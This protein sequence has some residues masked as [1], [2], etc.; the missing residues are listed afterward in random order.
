MRFFNFSSQ[1]RQ[2]YEWYWHKTFSCVFLGEFSTSWHAFCS[3]CVG[4]VPAYRPEGEW[5]R[6]PTGV[7]VGRSVAADFFGDHCCLYCYEK[8]ASVPLN[9]IRFEL[10]TKRNHYVH[11]NNLLPYSSVLKDMH[12]QA[13]Q[14][15][16]LTMHSNNNW[17]TSDHND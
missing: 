4:T 9:D 13:H 11:K 12:F 2:S 1:Y 15:R 14:R 8:E 3:T 5:L 17:N 10:G 6:L 7:G 16:C